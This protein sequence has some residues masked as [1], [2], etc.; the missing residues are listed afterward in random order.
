MITSR[1]QF[2]EHIVFTH[3][4]YII[5]SDEKKVKHSSYK[6]AKRSKTYKWHESNGMHDC[7]HDKM[8]KRQ[9]QC[10]NKYDY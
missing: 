10:P 5:M 3:K 4:E 8:K 9:R 1:L 7:M 2:L 6:H